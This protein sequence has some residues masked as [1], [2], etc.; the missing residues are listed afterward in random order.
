[1]VSLL[2]PLQLC[3]SGVASGANLEVVGSLCAGP[4]CVAGS[5]TYSTTVKLKN[6]N[7]PSIRLEQSST[8]GWTAQTWD[9]AGNETNFF[10]RDITNGSKLPFRIR[11]GA[12][13]S[14]IDISA[15]GFVGIGTAAPTVKLDIVGDVKATNYVG[16]GAGLTDIS[17]QAV[18]GTVASATNAS[19][20]AHT[21]E[22]G[23][24]ASNSIPRWNGIQLISG[25]ISDD[26][27]GAV[28][29]GRLT[30]ASIGYPS[31]ERYKRNIQPLQQSLD[32]ITSLKGVSYEWRTDEFS[33]KGFEDGRQIGLI[34]Q[35]VE[36]ILPELVLTDDRGFKAVSYDKLVPVLIEAV[37]EQQRTISTLQDR[38]AK[39]EAML[40]RR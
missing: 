28:V 39:L 3:N 23:S 40:A 22:I 20:C 2:V 29:N 9:V 31:D 37:K 11:P 1:M 34:A 15:N 27:I 32:N 19:S 17:A 21:A 4:E 25:T 14:T 16:S 38:M 26:G 12:P 13:S 10:I 8:A 35:E 7:T 30:V 5:E 6:N 24:L 33:G 18:T 36:K